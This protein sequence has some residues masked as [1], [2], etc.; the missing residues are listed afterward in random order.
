MYGRL[1]RLFYSPLVRALREVQDHSVLTYLD[2]FKYG[3]AGEFGIRSEYAKKIR[4]EPGFGLEV[5]LLGEA[6]NFAG[7]EATAQVDLGVY[8]HFHRGVNGPNG[9]VEMSRE[10]GGA[11][12]GILHREG[13]EVKYDVVRREYESMA[14]K[15]IREYELDA[16][17]ND[18]TYDIQEE[19][20]Q[21]GE[22]AKSIQ[23]SGED[24]R[25]KSWDELGIRGEDVEDVCVEDMDLI[26][27]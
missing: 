18:L 2:A 7:F 25:I 15:F 10:V 12:F 11:L 19:L 13:V 16:L 3:V 6:F 20:E 21:I 26:I 24:T 1:C 14:N 8:E 9:L 22:Y 5:G 17:Y 23:S 27:N 4:I